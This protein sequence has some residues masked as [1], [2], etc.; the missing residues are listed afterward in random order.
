MQTTSTETLKFTQ[1]LSTFGIAMCPTSVSVPEG[2]VRETEAAAWLDTISFCDG[3]CQWVD[4]EEWS[5]DS[6]PTD[7][8]QPVESNR[9][10]EAV[11]EQPS[12]EKSPTDVPTRGNRRSRIS[13]F[14]KRAWKAV[15]KPFLCC[16]R[17]RVASPTPRQSDPDP[18]PV[19]GPSGLQNEPDN[20][21]TVPEPS[22]PDLPNCK[23]TT[24]SF[25][26]LY[27]KQDLIGRG[28]YGK[29]LK[30]IRK[31]DGQE[32]AIKRM[33]KWN[34]RHSLQMPGCSRRLPTEVALL[35]MLRRP[36]VCPYVIEMYEWFDR[37]LII[38]L[39][40][41]FPQPCVTLREFIRDSHGL[42]EPIARGFMRQLVA[43]VQHC[44]DRGV[45]HNDVHADNVLVNTNTLELKLIDFGSGHLLDDAGYDSLKY[46]GALQFC[47]PEVFS[48]PK[49]YAV[50][51][52][53]WALGVTLY[54]MVN[55]QPPFSNV[56]EILEAC[57]YTWKYDVSMACCDLIYQCLDRSPA[58]RPTFEQ[59]LQHEWFE[60]PE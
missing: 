28:S 7:S 58:K 6:L 48:R 12:A 4:D 17:T 21:Q 32:V 59:I 31:S 29:V 24:K 47:P 2:G 45:F 39:V 5:I 54:M 38:S 36:P 19:L 35:L 3:F 57:P 44:I 25:S 15:K 10:S 20:D 42:T 60:S 41:E 11:N 56:K 1:G 51:T 49:Y 16:R 37:P 46:I 22:V 30:A 14:F 40:L 26:K 8:Q 50:P 23:P 13:A 9:A 34:N 43:G 53:V 52:N 33:R 27:K 18:E 55:M